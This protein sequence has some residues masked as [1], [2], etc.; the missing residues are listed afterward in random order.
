MILAGRR[1]M[2]RVAI[3]ERLTLVVVAN[4]DILHLHREIADVAAYVGYS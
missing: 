1:Y 4:F 2:M 3:L